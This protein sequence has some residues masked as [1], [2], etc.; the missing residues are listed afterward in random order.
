ML[1]QVNGY[2][3]PGLVVDMF[4]TLPTVKGELQQ[5]NPLVPNNDRRTKDKQGN[6]SIP[7][8]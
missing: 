6:Y 2:P 3:H 8:K 5:Y 4:Y 7:I 1:I